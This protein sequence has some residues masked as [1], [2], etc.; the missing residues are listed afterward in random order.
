MSGISGS[1][2]GGVGTRQNNGNV[3]LNYNKNRFSLS[4][5]AGGNLTW[6]Q[7]TKT[8]FDQM[9]SSTSGSIVND[10]YSENTMKRYGTQNS[11]SVNYDFNNFNAISSTFRF[12]QGGFDLDGMQDNKQYTYDASGNQLQQIL[13]GATTAS[14]T[15]FGGF[16]W[17]ADYTRKFKKEGH[18][19]ILSGQW[20]HSKIQS[21]YLN[22]FDAIAQPRSQRGDNDGINDEYTIQL[23]YTLPVSKLLKVEAGGK[24]ILRRL[25]S[26][27]DIF[28]DVNNGGQGANP[29]LFPRDQQNSNTYDY[30]Q[31]V[32]AG[33]T[34][35]NFTLSPK[36]A[37]LVG[38]RYERTNID[39]VPTN[40]LQ[41]IEPFSNGYNTFIPSLTLQ[42]KL[43]MT[44]TMKLTYSK[45]IQRPSLQF[46]N[47]FVNRNNNFS[48]SQGNPNLDPEISQTIELNY[49]TFIKAS[50]INLSV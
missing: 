4:I 14:K 30:N 19:L 17:N 44:Q 32:Y 1:V 35:L 22:L 33:Y 47:P 38:G 49:N 20:S 24:S 10:N 34:V 3:N 48:Q 37:I 8:D 15:T 2:S 28:S 18:E 7:T 46:L 41:D 16:D 42:R 23:D 5:N 13:Y 21:N 31:N 43:S 11:A 40:D 50:V 36:N 27:Y 39:G 29:D 26:V 12:S 9:L 25:S 45:R 6:P